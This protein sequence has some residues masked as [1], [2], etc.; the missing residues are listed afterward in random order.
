MGDRSASICLGG[1]DVQQGILGPWQWTGF[2][3]GD[4]FLHRDLDLLLDLLQSGDGGDRLLDEPG[5]ERSDGVM[6]GSQIDLFP[7]PR[8]GR[9]PPLFRMSPPALGLA[10]Y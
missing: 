8:V 9:I 1:K 2:G 6:L 4:G 10:L 5:C 7:G 3:E